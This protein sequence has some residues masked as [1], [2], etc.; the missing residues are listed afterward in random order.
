MDDTS[1]IVLVRT[2]DG[3]PEDVI[4][5]VDRISEGAATA[6]PLGDHMENA[7]AAANGAGAGV[8]NPRKRRAVIAAGALSSVCVGGGC[9]W[10]IAE[11]S[12]RLCLSSD[13]LA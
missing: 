12:G 6:I 11:P 3:T 13:W 2:H 1:A 5:A 9:W 4:A 7:R 10:V 8:G